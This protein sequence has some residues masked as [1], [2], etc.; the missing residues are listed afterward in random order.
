MNN[1]LTCGLPGKLIALWRAKHLIW[2]TRAIKHRALRCYTPA[3]RFWFT[4]IDGDLLPGRP[5][6]MVP[7]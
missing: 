7:A 5:T 6:W 1:C 4:G 3:C 2:H